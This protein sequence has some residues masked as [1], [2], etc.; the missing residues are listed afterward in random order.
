ADG[1]IRY[2]RLHLQNRK[3]THMC[4]QEYR[5][6]LINNQVIK[7]AEER[8]IPEDRRLHNRFRAS[9]PDDVLTIGTEETSRA[10]IP[11][12]NILYVSMDQDVDC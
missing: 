3:V 8:F 4:L 7:A 5:I 12:R 10:F 9:K 2:H 1:S 11:V 6:H